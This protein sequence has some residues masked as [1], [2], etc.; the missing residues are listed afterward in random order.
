MVHANV[1]MEGTQCTLV[2]GVHKGKHY[3]LLKQRSLIVGAASF[4][5]TWLT[6]FSLLY[7]IRTMKVLVYMSLIAASIL[8]K[9]Q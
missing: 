2:G 9:M 3:D 1:N 6:N 5:S 7:L 8:M 4:Q